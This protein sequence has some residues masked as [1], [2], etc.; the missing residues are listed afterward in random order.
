MLSIGDASLGNIFE[1]V[2]ITSANE[3]IK[4]TPY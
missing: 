2:N 4:P 1:V 3:T